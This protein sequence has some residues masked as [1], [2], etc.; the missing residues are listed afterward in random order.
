LTR[1][2]VDPTRREAEFVISVFICDDHS[3]VREAIRAILDTEPDITVIGEAADSNE[4]VKDIAAL[5]PDV[6]VLDHPVPGPEPSAVCR[7]IAERRL[8]T[9]TLILSDVHD[10]VAA[11]RAFMAG[12]S[13]YVLK[14]V[15]ADHLK[16]EI[17]TVVKRDSRERSSAWEIV[18]PRRVKGILTSSEMRVLR[19]LVQGKSNPEIAD[20]TGLTHETV[21]SYTR[22]IYRKLNVRGREEAAVVA[23]QRGFL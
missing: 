5:N 8:R 18:A 15:S 19:L 12:A 13:R 1:R 11:Q 2:D 22:A 3:I 4:I 6:L 21:K 14:D 17:R 20:Q 23:L 16:N 10:D 9:Q 7:E